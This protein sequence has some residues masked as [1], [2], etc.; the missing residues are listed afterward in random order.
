MGTGLFGCSDQIAENA[1]VYHS[2]MAWQG[3]LEMSC[4]QSFQVKGRET[5]G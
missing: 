2:A 1:F 3:L 4:Q 5:A